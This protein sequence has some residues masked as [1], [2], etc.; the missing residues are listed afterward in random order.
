MPRCKQFLVLGVIAT[1]TLAT[2]CGQTGIPASVQ[3]GTAPATSTP[4]SVSPT[5]PT[6]PRPTAARDLL[7]YFA[8]ARR[9][10]AR[11][12]AAALAINAEIG[13]GGAPH[14]SQATKNAVERADPSFAAAD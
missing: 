8:A 9:A 5:V 14:F 2:G 13:T 11:I 10:D 12:H 3:P 1:A 7:R 4:T 6:P